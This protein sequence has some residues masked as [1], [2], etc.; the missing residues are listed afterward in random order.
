MSF[1]PLNS[2]GGERRLNVLISR[3]KLRCEVSHRS[4]GRHRSVEVQRK[5]R[6]GTQD[7]PLLRADRKAR[8]CGRDGPKRRFG[9]EEQVAARL[10]ASVMM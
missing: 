8:N 9:F 4:P 6:C 7:V 1:G 5:G 10:T 3:A 2:D